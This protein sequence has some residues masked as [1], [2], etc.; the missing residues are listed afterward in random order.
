MNEEK[1]ILHARR[2]LD[3]LF[4]EI[5]TM[6]VGVRL[7]DG[8]S[9]PDNISRP[10]TLVLKHPGALSAMF[11]S[12]TELGLAEAYLYDDFDI[13]GDMEIIFT[14]R[15]ALVEATSGWSRKLRALALLM[16]MPRFPSRSP[17]ARRGPANLTGET[18]SKERDRQAVAYHYDVSNEFYALWLDRNMVY[19]CGYFRSAEDDLDAAQEQKLEYICRKLRLKPGQRFLDIGCGWGSLVLYAAKHYGVEATGVTLSVPQTELANRRIAEAGLKHRAKVFTCDY[20]EIVPP[21]G[22]EGYDALASVGMCEH[23]GAS[24]LPVYFSGAFKLLKPGG[25]FLNH[26]ITCRAT[27]DRT[28]NHPGFVG[29]YVFPDGELTPIGEM[30]ETAERVGFEVRDV[31][32]LR[33]HYTLTLRHW[34]RRLESRHEETLRYVD[35]PTYRVWRL[36]MAIAA[37]LFVT[38]WANVYQSLLVKPDD[39]GRSG[40]P[41]TRRLWYMSRETENKTV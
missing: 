15:E 33:E 11:A 14:L 41:L 38:G 22:A 20:R 21:D 19:S 17:K 25:V 27:D 4:G 23:V 8:T 30:I 24:M 36:Y 16:P 34:V 26:G 32:S 5:N 35:E 3:E 28:D 13:E 37:Q 18:H 6:K 31:E 2:F 12:G 9:W 39:Q 1:Q 10:V 40:F 29:K 7:W